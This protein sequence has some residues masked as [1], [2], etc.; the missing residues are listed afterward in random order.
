MTNWSDA[1]ESWAAILDGRFD[2]P[3]WRG[4]LTSR[5]A[6]LPLGGAGELDALG[7]AD[8]IDGYAASGR[9]LAAL[10]VLK[11]AGSWAAEHELL[12]RVLRDLLEISTHDSIPAADPVPAEFL[13]SRRPVIA[14]SVLQRD[15]L[16]LVPDSE[17]QDERD[18]IVSR[19]PDRGPSRL[20]WALVWSADTEVAGKV[21][22]AGRRKV[23]RAKLDLTAAV[24]LLGEAH[25]RAGATRFSARVTDLTSRGAGLEVEDRFDRLHGVQILGR[26][27]RLALGVPGRA[28]P[29]RALAQVRW[30][31]AH[32][33][34]RRT[35]MGVEFLEVS[36]ELVASIAV[37]LG[38]RR[39]I[40]YLWSLIESSTERL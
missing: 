35:R 36:D 39:D 22:P 34:E 21:R 14:W 6:L 23:A 5:R 20:D 29:L 15:G 1:V 32:E 12:R 28:D 38:G 16:A 24:A 4:P 7:L 18:W 30:T 25:P 40:Q 19:G 3:S 10:T 27:V 33:R 8:L 2:R 9:Y 31:E 37:L 26:R 13:G 11:L 17:P